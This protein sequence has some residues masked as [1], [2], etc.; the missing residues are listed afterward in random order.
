MTQPIKLVKLTNGDSLITKIKVNE[1]EEYATLI[2]PM[3]VHKWMAQDEDGGGA[4]ENATFGPWESFSNDQVFHIAKNQI[5]TLTN[6][7]ED[8]IRYYHR[9]LDKVKSAP[10][11]SFDEDDEITNMQ[12]LKEVVDDL[13]EK[14]GLSSGDTTE[15]DV[16]EYMY[17][18]DKI[19]KH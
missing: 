4:Y 15:E 1:N 6:P 12:K 3:R 7:R 13:N 9:L 2:E 11:D 10:I 5:L 19:T 8:V 17:N 16:M 14:L 18:K